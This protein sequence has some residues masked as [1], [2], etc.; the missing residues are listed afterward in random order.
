MS[1]YVDRLATL[2]I[3]L[4]RHGKSVP[5]GT[6]GWEERDDERPLSA[7]GLAAAEE[8]AEELEPYVIHA[9]Y[10]SPYARAVQTITP[11]AR[12]RGL[13]IQVL[14]DLRERRLTL[15]PRDDWRDH[16]ERAWTDPDYALDGAE[17]GRAAQRR[18]VGVLDLLRVRH[19]DGGR[20]AVSSHGNLIALILQ[21]LEPEVDFAFHQAMPFPALYHLQHDGIGWRVMGGHGFIEI[22]ETN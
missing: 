6:P 2:D 4:I 18:G 3:L 21:A 8:L 20:I 16:L 22:A 5:P 11:L 7:A 19:P 12:R 17:A 13:E 14:D 1:L 10:S 9:V 15:R